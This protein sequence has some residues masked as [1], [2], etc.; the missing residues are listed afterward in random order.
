MKN[1]VILAALASA[2]VM[3]GLQYGVLDAPS[4]PDPVSVNLPTEASI[5]EEVK[6][7]RQEKAIKRA[8]ASARMVYRRNGC[9]DT[10]SEVTGRTAYEYGLSPRLLAA[11]VFVESS[12]RASAVSGANS[13]GLLQVNPRVWG[14]RRDLKD[15][16]TNLHIGASIL[17]SYMHRYG[18]VEG[19]HHFNGYS[20]VHE[21]VYVNKILTAA[22]LGG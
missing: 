19:L 5:K 8:V 6:I 9:K 12:C 13:I 16:E 3:L 11:M 2:L 14:H 4:A 22:G 7:E 21:H 17:A 18:L 10:Y 15:P 1:T 20:E